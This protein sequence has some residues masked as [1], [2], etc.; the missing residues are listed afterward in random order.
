MS[1]NATLWILLML[2]ASAVTAATQ[3]LGPG[4]PTTIFA[5]GFTNPCRMA[6]D[7]SGDLYVADLAA[8]QIFRVTPD[9]SRTLFS[10]DITDPRGVTFDAFS[11]LLVTTQTDSAVYAISADGQATKFF[12]VV[13]ASGIATGPDG[14]LWVAAV[15]SVHHFDAMGRHLESIDVMSGGAAAF[16][17]GFSPTGEVHISSFGAIHKLVTGIPVPVA[18]GQPIQ[19]RGFAFDISGNFY[20]SHRTLDP[21]SLSRVKLY[22]SAGAVLEDTFVTQVQDPCANSFARDADGTTTNRMFI[23]QLDGV[24]REA[25]SAG[26]AAPGWPV[27]GLEIEA[28]SETQ[29]ADQLVGETEDLNDNQARFLDVIGNNNGSYDLGDFRAYLVATGVLSATTATAQ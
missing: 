26:I 13:G 6:F 21:D 11:R 27:V 10:D 2:A 28:I 20:W 17:I 24:I 3:A 5:S 1:R 16:G 4:D 14:S 7:A 25:N 12:D 18:T 8:G 22:S 9:G 15:D 19:M 29:A 23:A